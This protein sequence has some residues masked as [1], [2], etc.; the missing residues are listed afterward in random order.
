MSHPGSTSSREIRAR[1]DHPVIDADGHIIEFLPA[2][3]DFLIEEGGRK[4]AQDFDAA[5]AAGRALESLPMDEK[6][7]LGVFMLDRQ[8]AAGFREV[9][10]PLLVRDE[11]LCGTGQLPK[12]AEGQFRTPDGRWLI[13]TA[14]ASVT[15]LVR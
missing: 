6:R 11:A 5:I 3:R 7:A 2:V 15:H 9:V 8:T 13:P 10:P 4:L 12:F 14:E 1:L